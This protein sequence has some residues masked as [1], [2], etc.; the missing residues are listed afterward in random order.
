MLPSSDATKPARSGVP[1]THAGDPAAD[2]EIVARIAAVMVR[3]WDAET[4][5][6]ALVQEAAGLLGSS[7]VLLWLTN[8][9]PH[10]LTL[11]YT[12]GLL[13]GQVPAAGA[14]DADALGIL[15]RATAAADGVTVIRT[16]AGTQADPL[17]S[18]LRAHALG[19]LLLVPLLAHGRLLGVVGLAGSEAEAFE[20]AEPRRAAHLLGDL[21][22]LAVEST[23]LQERLRETNA[24]LVTASI[25]AQ[26]QAEELAGEKAEREAFISLIAH[27]LK[28]PL[29]VLKLHIARLQRGKGTKQHAPIFQ[30]MAVSADRLQRLVDDLLDASRIAT[31]HFSVVLAPVDVVAAVRE[32]TREQQA[33]TQ[34]HRIRFVAERDELT[35]PL[36]RQ[37]LAQ[38]LSNLISNAIKYSPDGGDITVRLAAEGEWVRI[39]VEDQGTGLS[40]ADLAHLFEPYTRILRVREA[41]GTG[42]GLFITKG[43]AEAHGGT[44]T[45]ASPGVGQGSIFT[46]MIR[47]PAPRDAPGGAALLS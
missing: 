39:A 16:G 1:I 36:D 28:N 4:V 44:I 38:A 43:I 8:V 33:L 26:Q 11:A 27:E 10:E 37:R 35:C 6:R 32:V 7:A 14:A 46:L 45:V 12:H 18:F 2:L 3:E 23:G 15:G 22:A 41:R 34:R 31:G 40:D 17:A 47:C 9:P 29:A 19:A 13:P 25:A 24:Q 20:G 30:T 21:F 42:L 5:L